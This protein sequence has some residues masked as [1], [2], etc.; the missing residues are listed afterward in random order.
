[1][2]DF[3]NLNSYGYQILERVENKDRGGYITWKAKDLDS[4]QLVLVKQFSFAT[5]DSSWSGYKAYQKE[6]SILQ[7]LNHPGIPE[8]IESFET[9]KGFCLIQKYIQG[10]NLDQINN[11]TITQIKVI[12]QKILEI[13]VY[14]QRQNPPISHQNI[15]PNNVLIDES[16]DIY[17][18]DFRLA[19]NLNENTSGLILS[20]PGFIAPKQDNIPS[21]NSD[22]YSVGATIICLLTNKKTSE[23]VELIAPDNPYEIQFQNL[24]SDVDSDFINWVEKM[25]NPEI[26]KGFTDAKSALKALKEIDWDLRSNSI[27]IRPKDISL[28]TE[29]YIFSTLI[30]GA[31]GIASSIGFQVTNKVTDKTIINIIITAIAFVVLYIAQYGAT[32]AFKTNSEGK[33]ETL[34][35]AIGTPIILTM[36][37]GL[38]FGKGEAVAISFATAIAQTAILS[39][40]LWQKLA[41]EKDHSQ[42]LKGIGLLLAITLGIFLGLKVTI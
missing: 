35:F 31:L 19:N 17:L 9:N 37:A 33:T 40:I 14:L 41:L 27:T 1:M 12:A 30:M 39:T 38:I 22:L 2:D 34:I 42:L 10:K 20:T 25:V 6:V 11:F 32:T 8:Y 29:K 13:L 4:N 21:K 5:I 23:I 36:T 18:V 15:N 7:N 24:I 28:S 16:G 3:P 26:E